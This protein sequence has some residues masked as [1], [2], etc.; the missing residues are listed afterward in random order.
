MEGLDFTDLQGNN[1]NDFIKA[2]R[3]SL[4]DNYIAN[5]N[6]IEQQRRNDEASIMAN[7]NR[8]GMMYSNF[9]ARD[10][11][12]YEAETYLPNRQ[13]AFT[14]YQTGLDKLR[15]NAVNAY[16]NIRSI[17][18]AI[19]DLNSSGG[20]GGTGGNTGGNTGGDGV[21]YWGSARAQDGGTWF[22]DNNDNPVRFST[23]AIKNGAKTSSDLLKYAQQALNA[24]E[25]NKL[26]K[27]Y[28]A[29]SA[30]NRTFTRNTG[31]NY[32]DNNYDFLT[33]DE[34]SFLNNLGLGF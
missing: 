17:E 30:K 9:P 20:G 31:K 6:Q 34:N 8:A 5:V 11:M 4:R 23:W 27:I 19:S 10:K 29:Q 32:T 15:S 24:N 12:K 22:Y 14:S 21:K 18:D 28:D 7:A 3:D 26:K 25:Y 33:K 13:S 1:V 2:Y 16:N